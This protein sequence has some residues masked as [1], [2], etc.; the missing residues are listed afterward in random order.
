LE[1]WKVIGTFCA[2]SYLLG[3]GRQ[4]RGTGGSNI[5]V[6]GTVMKEY[7]W[8]NINMEKPAGGYSS[9][10][11]RMRVPGGFLYKDVTMDHGG[12]SRPKFVV[13]MAFVPDAVAGRSN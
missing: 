10:T 11:F 7:V 4:I 12:W 9:L 2:D 5:E 6:K 1:A 13:A 3:G 8:E